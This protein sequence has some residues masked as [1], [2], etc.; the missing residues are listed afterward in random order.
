MIVCNIGFMQHWQNSFVSI[1]TIMDSPLICTAVFSAFTVS[2]T[3]VPFTGFRA[4]AMTFKFWTASE[5]E[6]QNNHFFA[7]HQ[8]LLQKQTNLNR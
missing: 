8:K 3:S 5:N 6:K 2:F 1:T 4:E 7:F